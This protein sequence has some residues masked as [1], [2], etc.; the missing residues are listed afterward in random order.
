MNN[1]TILKITLRKLNMSCV[2]NRILRPKYWE[3][4]I[5]FGQREIL[6]YFSDEGDL[7]ED[8]SLGML[9][10]SNNKNKDTVAEV[11]GIH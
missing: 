6:S 11:N 7:D 3:S 1:A 9:N 4:L 10:I 5:T 2:K 8:V